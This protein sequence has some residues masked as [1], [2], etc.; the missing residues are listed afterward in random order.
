MNILLLTQFLPADLLLHFDVI[1]LKEL[2][3]LSTRKDC[4][5]IYLDEK[6]TLPIGLNYCDDINIQNYGRRFYV[7]IRI[8]YRET[9]RFS[10]PH[11]TPIQ[12]KYVVT[13]YK[14]RT[15]KTLA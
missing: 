9:I 6:N 12:Y 8:I 14:S 5:Y 13:N 11:F 3:D 7:K 1:A 10:L 15:S 4:I 2:G